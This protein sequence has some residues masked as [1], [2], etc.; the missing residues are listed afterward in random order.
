MASIK[1][2]EQRES[3]VDSILSTSHFAIVKFEKTK[4]QALE[5]LRKQ[6]KQ[7]QSSLKVMKNSIFLKALHDLA[8]KNKVYLEIQKYFSIIKDNSAILTL[9]GDWS[10]GLSDFYAF[11]KKDNT[12]SFKLAFLDQ[13]L[14]KQDEVVRLAQLPSKNV[15]LGKVIG[16]LKAPMSKTVYAMKYNVQKL[17][18]IL[19]TKSK[20]VK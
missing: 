3:I 10:K 20:E 7:S 8:T 13:K 17:V 18:F 15:L 4:H 16:S 19:N 1:K 6:L 11:S 5:E 14:Y 9:Q 2:T 12:L